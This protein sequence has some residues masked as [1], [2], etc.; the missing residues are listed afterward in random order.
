MTGFEPAEL[1]DWHRSATRKGKLREQREPIPKA[2]GNPVI[3]TISNR[4]GSDP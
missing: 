1:V 2:E 4:R 3:P